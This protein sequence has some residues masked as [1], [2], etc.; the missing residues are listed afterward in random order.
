MTTFPAS[1]D[2]S[3]NVQ[4]VAANLAEVHRRIER[5]GGDPASVAV[6]AVTKTFRSDMVIA[7][8][9]AGLRAVGENYVD[10]L[11]AKRGDLPDLD[12]SWHYLG[13]LQSN[14]IARIVHVADVMSGVSRAKEIRLIAAQR[15][16]ATIDVQVDLTG[17]P[18]RNG[19]DIADVAALVDLARR[20]GLDVRGL[21]TVA[22]PEVRPR[23]RA[24]CSGERIMRRT[25]CSR[26]ID[27]DERRLGTGRRAGQ[28]RSSH[29]SRII[30]ST[31][32]PD[33]TDLT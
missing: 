1:F 22:S 19:A 31:T 6:V 7:A 11:E 20:V 5:A 9:A 33:P 24:V 13:A 17:E 12:L 23:E 3:D 15:P 4:R 30:W 18:E 26:A 21:M 16:G 32:Y 2:R 25:R 14:K 27:G 29:W 8:R 10:E 28:H